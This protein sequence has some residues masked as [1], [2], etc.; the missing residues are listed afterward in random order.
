ME[1]VDNLEKEEYEKFLLDSKHAHFMQSYDFGIIR[2]ENILY[3][4][5]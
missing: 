2:K 1:F 5:M 3:H 4:I